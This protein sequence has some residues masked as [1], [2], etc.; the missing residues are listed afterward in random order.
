MEEYTF[1]NIK[2]NVGLSDHD[3]DRE[4]PSYDFYESGKDPLVPSAP[5]PVARRD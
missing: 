5:N 1:L 3:F 2:V 4:N